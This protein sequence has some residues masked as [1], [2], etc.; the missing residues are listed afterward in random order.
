MTAAAS[1]QSAAFS[2]WI[3]RARSMRIEDVLAARGFKLRGT[4]ERAG[5]CPRCGGDDRFSIRISDQIFNC[6]KCGAKGKG[7]IDLIMF[8]DNCDFKNACETLTREPSTNNESTGDQL[9]NEGSWIYRDANDQPY[10]KVVRYRLPDGRKIYPQSHWDG[11]KWVKGKPTGPKLPYRLPQLLAGDRTEPVWI[12]E[13]EKC[14]DRLA[15]ECLTATS[16]S[17][18][19]GKWKSELNEWFSGRICYIVPDNDRPGFEHAKQVADSLVGIAAEVKIVKL[20]DLQM[21]GDDVFEWLEGGH[22][23]DELE[24]LASRQPVIN[25]QGDGR[26]AG[27]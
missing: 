8:L 26:A 27:H 13:G 11:I 21:E 4:N 6:R 12:V 17:E 16:A 19:A 2:A 25:G 7:A 10:L 20:P 3:E 1:E 18:G 9:Q 22:T 15:R 23:A 24:K 14:A 5:P